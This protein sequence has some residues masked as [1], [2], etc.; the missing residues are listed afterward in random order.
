M[1]YGTLFAQSSHLFPNWFLSAMSSLDILVSKKKEPKMLNMPKYIT[2][3]NF[4]NIVFHNPDS[5][6]Q[7]PLLKYQGNNPP[8]IKIAPV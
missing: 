6:I 8:N 7:V 4:P 1:E 2:T 5:M 3:T